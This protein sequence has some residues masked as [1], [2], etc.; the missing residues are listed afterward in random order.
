MFE[1]LVWLSQTRIARFVKVRF[2]TIADFEGNAAYLHRFSLRRYKLHN[3]VRADGDRCSHDHPWWFVRIILYGGYTEIYGPDNR[4]RELKVWRPWFF[5]R[6]YWC[7]H[8]FRHRITKL[9]NGINSWSFV[10]TGTSE[11]PWGFFTK[12]GWMKWQDFVYSPIKTRVLWCDDGTS[13]TQ[14]PHKWKVGEEFALTEPKKIRLKNSRIVSEYTLF[15]P[16][17]VGR[18]WMLA[19]GD[20]FL[21]GEFKRGEDTWKA[22]CWLNE[23]TEVAQAQPE[24][25]VSDPS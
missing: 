24:A 17:T 12:E 4:E 20:K 15:I 13:V 7:P 2:R 6:I 9:T 22:V 16:G 19:D 5:W 10:I 14:E 11:R 8:D 21:H 18:V 23:I 3:I 1:L 25:S